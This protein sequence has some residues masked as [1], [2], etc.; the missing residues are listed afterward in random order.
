MSKLLNDLSKDLSKDLI[1]T[2]LIKINTS[3]R[4]ICN[5]K[6]KSPT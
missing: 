6:T 2:D 4:R 3:H 1:M 5:D